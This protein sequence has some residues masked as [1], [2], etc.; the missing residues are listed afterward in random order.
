MNTQICGVGSCWIL[1]ASLLCGHALTRWDS[2]VVGTSSLHSPG[3]GAGTRGQ[4]GLVPEP[5]SC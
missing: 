5:G 3:D 4:H 1:P 2:I